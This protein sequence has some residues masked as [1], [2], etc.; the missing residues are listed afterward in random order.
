M[1][2]INS[3]K[4]KKNLNYEKYLRIFIKRLYTCAKQKLKSLQSNWS[5]KE[6]LNESHLPVFMHLHG[7]LTLNL[8]ALPIACGRYDSASSDCKPFRA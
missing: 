4:P 7:P 5:L 3:L 8:H 1:H 2:H 6:A